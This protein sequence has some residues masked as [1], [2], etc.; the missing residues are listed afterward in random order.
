MS[1]KA[2]SE[3]GIRGTRDLASSLSSQPRF[4]QLCFKGDTCNCLG[5]G[6][7]SADATSH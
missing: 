1:A 2:S 3:T 7:D 4:L 5:C 6:L